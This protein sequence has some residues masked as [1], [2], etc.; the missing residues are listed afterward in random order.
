MVPMLRKQ[1]HQTQSEIPTQMQIQY[2]LL[3][4]VIVAILATCIIWC[5]KCLREDIQEAVVVTRIDPRT[6]IY[7]IHGR[8]IRESL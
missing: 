4:L 7:T 6:K 8:E 3:A 1:S 2:I 5:T